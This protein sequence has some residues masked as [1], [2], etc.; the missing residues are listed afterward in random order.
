MTINDAADKVASNPV[1]TALARVAMFITPILVTIAL[2][3]VTQ[4]LN[5]QAEAL[6]GLSSRISV[7]ETLGSSL[8]KRTTVLEDSIVRGRQDRIEFQQRTEAI[9][10]KLVDQ[11]NSD[12]ILA[13]QVKTDVAYLRDYIEDLKRERRALE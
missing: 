9:L 3:V 2:F 11:M 13:A 10:E 8:D 6:R 7:T 1:L 12:R 4:Y 5:G